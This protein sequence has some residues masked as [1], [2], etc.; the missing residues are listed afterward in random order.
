M[1]V[2]GGGRGDLMLIFCVNCA[3]SPA[4]YDDFVFV[5]NFSGSFYGDF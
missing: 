3:E 4:V 5:G 1:C 2:S